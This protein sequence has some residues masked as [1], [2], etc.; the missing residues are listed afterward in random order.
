MN[1]AQLDNDQWTFDRLIPTWDSTGYLAEFIAVNFS[2]SELQQALVLAGGY[3]DTVAVSEQETMEVSAGVRSFIE[4][5]FSESQVMYAE[6][7]ARARVVAAYM[8]SQEFAAMVGARSGIFASLQE[9]ETFDHGLAARI[10]FGISFSQ[11]EILFVR[12]YEKITGS[13][14]FSALI[15]GTSIFR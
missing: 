2:Q 3:F 7:T 15:S 8:E 11:Y 9:H 13:S 12:S 14:D 1:L 10:F 5:R 4:A 6:L